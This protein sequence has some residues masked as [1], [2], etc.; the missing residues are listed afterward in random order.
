MA[1]PIAFI[2]QGDH[3][4][5]V[6]VMSLLPGATCSSGHPGNGSGVMC[7]SPCEHLPVP[8]QGQNESALCVDED[9]GLIVDAEGKTEPFFDA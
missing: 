6:A 8:I 3:F 9:S 1:I 2:P 7:P 5:A 4:D